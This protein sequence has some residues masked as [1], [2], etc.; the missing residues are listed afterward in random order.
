MVEK[1]KETAVNGGLFGTLI[2][3]FSKNYDSFYH[4]KLIQSIQQHL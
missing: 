1:W 4:T 2:T 3:D